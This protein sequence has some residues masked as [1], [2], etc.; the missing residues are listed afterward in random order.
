MSDAVAKRPSG[1]VAS[2]FW[3]MPSSVGGI[4]PWTADGLGTAPVSRAVAIA[5]A[6]SPVHGRRPVS[7][8]N[9]TMPRL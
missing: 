5:A 8:S 6:V 4:P 1:L 7:S 9:S 3:V 2:A